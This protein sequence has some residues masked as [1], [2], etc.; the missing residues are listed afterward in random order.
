MPGPLSRRELLRTSLGAACAT[1]RPPPAAAADG[2]SLVLLGDLHFDRPEHHD[3]LWVATTHPDD[4]QQIED[5]ARITR[6]L[7]PRFFDALRARIAELGRSAAMHTGC[8]VQAGDFVEGLCGSRALAVR[9]DEDALAFVR[10]AR[11]GAPFLFTKG[12]HDVT[13]PGAVEAF[14]DVFHPYLAEQARA[15]SPAAAV[16][17]ARCAVEVGCA[18]LVFYDAYDAESLA[19]FEAAAARR[20]AAHLFVIVHPPVVPYG[21]RS[22]WHLYSAADDASKRAK[23]LELLAAHEAFVLSGH[24]HRYSAIVRSVG[25][26]RFVQLST[27]SVV[28]GREV[29]AR[30][31]LSGVRDY[32]GDQIRVEPSF[33]PAT[34]APRRAALEAERPFIRAFEYADLPGYAVLA[35][36]RA[37]VSAEIHAGTER[38]PWRA[39][40][41]TQ[42]RS[43]SEG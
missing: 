29:R 31:W 38:T 20:T 25:R 27:C 18:Q 10:G 32:D 5:Y 43:G 19:W 41:L 26:R 3:R 30:D 23:V 13:G 28:G 33:S 8:V 12:N 7:M 1:V 4:L 21:A 39:L 35:V 40:D 24:T 17:S 9:Q 34:A 15:V 6:D 16:T 14:G 36:T 22:T 42:L 11:L 37:R 2:F